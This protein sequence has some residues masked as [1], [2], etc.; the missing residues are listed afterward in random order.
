M[1]PAE[2][3][4]GTLLRREWIGRSEVTS[5][6][7]ATL[8]PTRPLRLLRLHD[9]G[10]LALNLD[11]RIGASI[12]YGWTQRRALDL[13]ERFDI[14]GFASRSRYDNSELAVVLFEERLGQALRVVEVATLDKGR[15]AEEVRALLQQLGCQLTD[16]D[17]PR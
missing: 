7:A 14:D 3:P 16:E 4:D 1:R 9:A 11:A 5:R 17:R 8:A 15:R 2:G 10:L 13:F 12:D 6:S